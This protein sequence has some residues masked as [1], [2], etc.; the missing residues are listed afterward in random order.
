MS[1]DQSSLW[2][3]DRWVATVEKFANELA[4]VD[5]ASGKQWTFAQLDAE[6]KAAQSNEPVA[7]VSGQNAG[8]IFRILQAWRTG[9]IVCP[10]EFGQP[11][12]VFGEVPSRYA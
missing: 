10:L 9:Q 5:F 11:P 8:F 6:S 4:L 2:L 1:R 3:Y 12:P 7:Y